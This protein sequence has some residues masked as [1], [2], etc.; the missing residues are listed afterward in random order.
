MSVEQPL[1]DVRT[2]DVNKLLAELRAG[3]RS[4]VERLFPLVYDELKRIARLQ[5]RSWLEAESL[6]TTAL[7]H[8]A[9]IRLARGREGDWRD[10]AHFLAV[11]ATAMR[12]ILIDHARGRSRAKRG[13][14]R[15][16]LDLAAVHD[17]IAAA[18][19][20]ADGDADLLLALDA[21]L[22]RLSALSERKGRIVECCFYGGMS[23]ED[24]A[25]ALTISPASV[26][27]GW[28]MARAWLYRELSAGSTP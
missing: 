23:I 25:E 7:V 9:Y 19:S 27:R 3:D 11:A 12:T 17:L 21:A 10:R 26:K 6:N 8:E 2:S 13:H 20:A 4:A 15:A 22:D 16:P 24:T 14:G 1:P 28:A 5:R 18:P